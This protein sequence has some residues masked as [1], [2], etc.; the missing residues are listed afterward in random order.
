MEQK[1]EDIATKSDIIDLIAEVR[2]LRKKVVIR[3][4]A[5]FVFQVGVTCFLLSYSAN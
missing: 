4:F 3:M 5:F 2:D 1:L